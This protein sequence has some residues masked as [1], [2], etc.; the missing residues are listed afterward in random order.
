MPVI[1]ETDGSE[2]ETEGWAEEII[3]GA[4][5]VAQYWLTEGSHGWRLDVAND[6]SDEKWEEFR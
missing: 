1:I 6:V 2:Y 3:D 4:D 5:S